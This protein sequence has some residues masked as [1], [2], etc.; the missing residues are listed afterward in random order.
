MGAGFFDFLTHFGEDLG[1]VGRAGAEDD[2][3]V[4]RQVADGID[5]MGDA[6]LAGDAAYEKDIRLAEI[7]AEA[8]EF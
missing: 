3:R 2:L 8:G 1:G 5:E 4:G 7:D 6:F